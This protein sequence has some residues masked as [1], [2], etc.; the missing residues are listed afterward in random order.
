MLNI[1]YIPETKK[2]NKNLKSK[3]A[4]H[5]SSHAFYV[6]SMIQSIILASRHRRGWD[7]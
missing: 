1:L 6:K 4:P 7:F 3:L 5:F 2:V